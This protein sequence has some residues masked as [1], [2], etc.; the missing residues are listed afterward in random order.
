MGEEPAS[1]S[2]WV[3]V[4]KVRL[5]APVAVGAKGKRNLSGQ[6]SGRAGAMVDET[7]RVPGEPECKGSRSIPRFA[8]YAASNSRCERHCRDQASPPPHRRSYRG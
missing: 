2:R 6:I 1:G 7:A 8:V 5:D 3:G 4:Q